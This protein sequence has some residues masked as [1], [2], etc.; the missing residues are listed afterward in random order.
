MEDI[1]VCR[2]RARECRQLRLEL[3]DDGVADEGEDD[4]D[5]WSKVS[6]SSLENLLRAGTV[7]CYCMP[8]FVICSELFAYVQQGPASSVTSSVTTSVTSSRIA[9]AP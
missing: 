2:R 8:P 3:E 9:F 7:T 1:H 5:A 4:L 6:S